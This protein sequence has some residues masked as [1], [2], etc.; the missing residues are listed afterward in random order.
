[1][2]HEKLYRLLINLMYSDRLVPTFSETML[3]IE[4]MATSLVTSS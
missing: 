1:M 2:L 4:E 3:N